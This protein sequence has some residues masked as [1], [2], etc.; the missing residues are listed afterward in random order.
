MVK[1]FVNT[2]SVKMSNMYLGSSVSIMELQAAAKVKDLKKRCAF[3]YHKMWA[4]C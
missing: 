3:G 4:Y 1:M 2:A